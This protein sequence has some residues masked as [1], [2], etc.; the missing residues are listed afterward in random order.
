M[1]LPMSQFTLQFIMALHTTPQS[2]TPPQS[3]SPLQC[4]TQLQLTNQLQYTTQLLSTNQ[5]HT[6]PQLSTNQLFTPLHITHLFTSQPH[7]TQS[8][9]MTDQL[10]TNTDMLLPMTTQRLTLLPMRPVMAMPPMANTVLL[11]LM[12]AL[13]L[14]LIALPMLTL[15]MLLTLSTKVLPNT[16]NTTQLNLHPTTQLQHTNLPHTMPKT[17]HCLD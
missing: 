10:Y 17:A 7:A 4:I 15:A 12:V 2:I 3:I 14:L 9:E 1:L 16:Q 13:K 5:H 11:F 8:Q 6:L